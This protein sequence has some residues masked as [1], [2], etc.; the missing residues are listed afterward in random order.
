MSWCSYDNPATMAREWWEN[1]K[2][3]GHATACLIATKGMERV[4]P[5]EPGEYVGDFSA[6]D[7]SNLEGRRK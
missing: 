2:L 4:K 3:L 7:S 6:I 5:F 1:G